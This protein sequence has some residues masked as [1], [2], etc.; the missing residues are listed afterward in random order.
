M[1]DGTF[2]THG[3]V[4]L[5]NRRADRGIDH[6]LGLGRVYEIQRSALQEVPIAA[7][8]QVAL[9]QVHASHDHRIRRGTA[10]VK[11]HATLQAQLPAHQV[12]AVRRAYVD[13]QLHV[14]AQALRRWRTYC[15]SKLT[16][17]SHQVEVRSERQLLQVDLPA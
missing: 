1:I 9:V 11:V 10:N 15:S 13:I 16:H 17:H 5:L 7:E 8:D 4:V 6:R 14:V 3:D 12:N 2:E